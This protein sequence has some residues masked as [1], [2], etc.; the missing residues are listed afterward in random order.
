MLLL[1]GC[2]SL[3][4]PGILMAPVGALMNLDFIWLL[5]DTLNALMAISQADSLVSTVTRYFQTR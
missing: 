1:I 5:A 2:F 4:E 3:E